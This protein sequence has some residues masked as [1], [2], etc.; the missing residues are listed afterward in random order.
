MTGYLRVEI[1]ETSITALP[2]RRSLKFTRTTGHPCL[3]SCVPGTQHYSGPERRGGI[4][5]I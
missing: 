1:K 2:V 3:G 4:A 5:D